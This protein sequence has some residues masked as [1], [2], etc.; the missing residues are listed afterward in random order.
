MRSWLLLFLTLCF[1]AASSG[2]VIHHHHERPPGSQK[3]VVQKSGPPPHAPAHGY[4]HKHRS[5][6]GDVQLVFDSGLGVYVIVDVPDHYFHGDRYFKHVKGVWYTSERLDRDWVVISARKV[7]AGLAKR[8]AKA[9]G[10]KKGHA[11]HPAK[12]GY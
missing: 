6:H 5:A 12:H 11:K 4:R 1:T 9:K 8:Y 2:C 7:P 10:K 3:V